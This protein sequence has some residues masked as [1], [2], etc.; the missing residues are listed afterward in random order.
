MSL[1]SSA[2]SS[3]SVSEPFSLAEVVYFADIVFHWHEHEARFH[4]QRKDKKRKD[5]VLHSKENLKKACLSIYVSVSV[6]K[7]SVTTIYGHHGECVFYVCTA[8]KK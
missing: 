5:C 3:A 4:D 6:I 7:V 1:R 2:I 8:C